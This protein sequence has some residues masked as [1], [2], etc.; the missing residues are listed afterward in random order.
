MDTEE[1]LGLKLS[2]FQKRVVNDLL[3]IQDSI[4]AALSQEDGEQFQEDLW[5]HA[6]GGGGRT[7]VLKGTHIEKGGVN[8][9]AVTGEVPP[10]MKPNMHPDAKTFFA[11]GVS[12]VI[13]PKNPWVPIVH[14]NVRYFESDA[15]DAWIGGGIDLTPIILPE[16]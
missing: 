6:G 2:E 3:A 10:M 13:H 12:L 8:F 1:R 9:S 15:G 14:M 11:T 7:R 5:K 4:C 16:I